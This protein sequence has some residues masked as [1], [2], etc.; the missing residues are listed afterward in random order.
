MRLNA[1][2]QTTFLI[3]LIIVVAGIISAFVS[4]PLLTGISLWVVV[5]GYVLLALGSFMSGL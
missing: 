5:A 1:P 3:S 2:K 4:I